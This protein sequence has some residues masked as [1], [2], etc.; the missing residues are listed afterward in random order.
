MKKMVKALGLLCVMA[1]VVTGCTTHK[2]YT[3][4][5]ANGDKIKVE[6]NTSEGHDLTTLEE[7]FKISKDGEV[8]SQ[9]TFIK[10]EYYDTYVNAAETDANATVISKS[11]NNNIEYIYYSYNNGQWTEWNYIIKIKNSN[12][13]AV[14]AN[15]T[16]KEEAEKCFS[17]LTFSKAE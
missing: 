4:D 9:G 5:V 7:N 15:K 3:F 8:L 16:S 12:T 11:S 14:L 2:S 1:L 10:V 6:L 17:L 13:G